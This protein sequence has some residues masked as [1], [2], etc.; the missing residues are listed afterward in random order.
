MQS[1]AKFFYIHKTCR[2]RLSRKGLFYCQ[3]GVRSHED[4]GVRNDDATFIRLRHDKLL[5][6]LFTHFLPRFI[7]ISKS[8]ERLEDLEIHNPSD[9]ET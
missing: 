8:L 9:F 6:L 7:I 2:H 3:Q 1:L 4:D 5:L